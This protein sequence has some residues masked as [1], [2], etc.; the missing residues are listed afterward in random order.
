MVGVVDF[1][2]S[3]YLILS[4]VSGIFYVFGYSDWLK[5]KYV[6]KYVI[7]FRLMR[8]RF[9][10]FVLIGIS[11]RRVSLGRKGGEWSRKVGVGVLIVFVIYYV[12]YDIM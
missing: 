9:G 1:F 12:L 10:M 7:Y 5:D 3:G 6:I 4:E 2:G 11:F 8:A